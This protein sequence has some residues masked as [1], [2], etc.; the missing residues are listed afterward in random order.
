M[1]ATQVLEIAAETPPAKNCLKNYLV[2]SSL[3]VWDIFLYIFI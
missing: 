3:L 2:A 1:G